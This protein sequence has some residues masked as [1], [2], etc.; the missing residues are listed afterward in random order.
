MA[1]GHLQSERLRNNKQGFWQV[2]GAALLFPMFFLHP[3]ASSAASFSRHKYVQQPGVTQFDSYIKY[4]D[5]ILV[6]L[7]KASRHIVFSAQALHDGEIT[8]ALHHAKSRKLSVFVTLHP[9]DINNY[10]TQYPYLKMH[11]IPVMKKSWPFHNYS[12]GAMV[13]DGKIYLLG[14]DFDRNDHG[15][16]RIRLVDKD[17]QLQTRFLSYFLSILPG[18]FKQLNQKKPSSLAPPK[19]LRPRK[20]DIISRSRKLQKPPS[21]VKRRGRSRM[22]RRNKLAPN[23]MRP[24][25]RRSLGSKKY[26]S[27]QYSRKSQSRPNNVPLKLPGLPKYKVLGR[28]MRAKDPSKSK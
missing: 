24:D 14:S 27:Y 9:K 3:F 21:V 17:S 7:N 13:V 15:K 5:F 11:R 4:Q 28:N 6:I 2:L 25:L 20:T 16:L 8:S 26:R 12:R 22:R 10:L 1:L 19:S 18:S 23:Q